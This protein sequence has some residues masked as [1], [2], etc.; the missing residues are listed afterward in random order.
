MPVLFNI[1]FRNLVR[2]KR[3]NVLLGIT[4]AFGAMVLVLANAFSHGISKVLF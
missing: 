2:Q 1:S 4:I 3:R